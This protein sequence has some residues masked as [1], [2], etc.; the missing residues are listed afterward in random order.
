VVKRQEE[1]WKDIIQKEYTKKNFL[2]RFHLSTHEISELGIGWVISSVIMIFVRYRNT[3]IEG[4]AQGVLP[5][6]IFIS[7]FAFGFTFFTHELMHKFTAIKY[8]AK[9][10]YQI[11][12]QGIII[13]LIGLIIGFPI[14]AVGAVFWWGESSSSLGIRG[15]VSAAGPISNL[16]LAGL[17]MCI[18]GVGFL[19]L[20]GFGYLGELFI[21]FGLFGVSWNIFLGGFNML[22]IGILDGAKV[23]DWN[24]KIWIALF[25][26]FIVLG[27]FTGSLFGFF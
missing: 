18:Q 21:L 25:G 17:F 8:G 3:I 20:D 26:S 22:P 10:Y 24:P 5:D 19:M 15:R 14:I 12:K 16:A 13:A 23:L 4:I 1:D 9:A 7:L 11:T 27:I 6:E 2:D